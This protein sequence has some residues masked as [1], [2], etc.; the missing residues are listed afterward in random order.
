[1]KLSEKMFYVSSWNRTKKPMLSSFSSW[2]GRLPGNFV[3]LSTTD[4]Q[5][6]KWSELQQTDCNV[7]SME[8]LD[9]IYIIYN[10]RHIK[11]NWP[12]NSGLLAIQDIFNLC[13]CLCVFVVTRVPNYV[14]L[15]ALAPATVPEL[16]P[17]RI[18]N[19]VCSGSVRTDGVWVWVYVHRAA[20]GVNT[21]W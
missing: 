1:M 20:V 19:S 18:M 7:Q 2:A 4:R 16:W 11:T 5:E 15:F 17:N 14:H 13:V 6:E 8:E 12:N 9:V 10:I 3:H 21:T